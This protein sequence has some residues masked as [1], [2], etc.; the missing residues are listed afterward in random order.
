MTLKLHLK[1]DQNPDDKNDDHAEVKHTGR[2]FHNVI[3]Y[4]P[5]FQTPVQMPVGCSS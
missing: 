5:S 3:Y 4:F 2:Q 1:S